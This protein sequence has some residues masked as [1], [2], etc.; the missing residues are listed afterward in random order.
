[1]ALENEVVMDRDLAKSKS[2][3]IP[4]SPEPEL[5]RIHYEGHTV[6]LSDLAKVSRDQVLKS[7][8]NIDQDSES[9]KELRKV[10]EQHKNHSKA[11]FY[12]KG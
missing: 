7:D 2:G 9:L 1:M 6:T 3:Q 8:S 5:P 10:I 11:K 12:Y 4:V